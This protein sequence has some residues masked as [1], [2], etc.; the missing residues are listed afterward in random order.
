MHT[1]E[2]SHQEQVN[3]KRKEKDVLKMHRNVK[4]AKTEGFK[5]AKNVVEST[6]MKYKTLLKEHVDLKKSVD[7]QKSQYSVNN[8]AMKTQIRTLKTVND[9]LK[10]KIDAHRISCS[11]SEQLNLRNS[12]LTQDLEMQNSK[13]ADITA[14]LAASKEELN[15]KICIV[16]LKNREISKAEESVRSLQ[17]TIISLRASSTVIGVVVDNSS[18]IVEATSHKAKNK[19]VYKM[20]FRQ[21]ENEIKELKGKIEMLNDKLLHKDD[22]IIRLVQN[23]SKYENESEQKIADSTN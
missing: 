19:G 6:E 21:K 2:L 1:A 10:L 3:S 5:T 18:K 13:F 16:E 7:V 14:D 23:I 20:E 4:K 12:K 11:N 15:T 22:K 17:E 8:G 9:Q